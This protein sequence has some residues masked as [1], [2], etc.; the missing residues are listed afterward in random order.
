MVVSEVQD[1]KGSVLL[2]WV[3]V[4]SIFTTGSLPKC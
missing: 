1:S 4:L 2:F 3:L